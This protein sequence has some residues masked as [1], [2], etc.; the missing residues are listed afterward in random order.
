[1]D[2]RLLP[3]AVGERIEVN[4]SAG[5]LSVYVCGEGPPLL[6]IHSIN[7]AASAAEVR[8]LQSH[9]C[10]SRRVFC[11]DLPG[12]G[13]SERSER[14]YTPRLMTDALH[15]VIA[16]IRRRYGTAPIDALALSLSSE[17]LAR[18]AAEAPAMFRSVALMSP[19]GFSGRVVLRGPPGSTRGKR[20]LYRL[21]RGPGW[22]RGLFRG[23]TRPAVIR[24]FLER[25]WG[26]KAIDEKLWAAAILTARGA[27]A[28]HAPL[29]FLAGY[30]FSADI[31]RL[32]EELQLPVWVCHGVRGDFTDYRALELFKGRPNWRLTVFPT[33][34][35]P[36]FEMPQE[37][38]AQYESFLGE[39]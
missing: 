31:Q 6:L 4:G 18:A 35:L 29:Y 9:F 17:Y 3:A 8:P 16:F 30:L 14:A 19:T 24:Y 7:A 34:A 20:W 15:Q 1:M 33:G 11:I 21:L 22:G 28:E 10:S 23:L 13:C 26:S 36:H 39:P 5:R 12:F 25:T 38:C 32:Y 37:F 27:G 2:A